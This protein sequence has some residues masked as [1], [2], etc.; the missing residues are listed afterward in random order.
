MRARLLRAELA[1]AA[2]GFLGSREARAL[3]AWQANCRRGAGNCSAILESS[4]SVTA[5]SPPEQRAAPCLSLPWQSGARLG[6]A[7]NRHSQGMAAEHFRSAA[8][9]AVASM[10]S[11]ENL[12]RN[13]METS[14]M[15]IVYVI[16]DRNNR[17]Y[18]NRIGVAFTNSDGSVNVK[19]EAIPVTGEMQIREYVPREETAR[20]SAT[21]AAP[22]LM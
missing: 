13:E 5:Q 15:K 17:K 9:E 14:R 19:L 11:K 8:S 7:R 3:R 21:A 4:L 22:A 1:R 18:W 20:R 12:E 2:A 10:G 6:L 16:T